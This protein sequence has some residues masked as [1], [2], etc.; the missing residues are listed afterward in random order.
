MCIFLQPHLHFFYVNC[1]DDNGFVRWQRSHKTTTILNRSENNFMIG[2]PSTSGAVFAINKNRSFQ[3]A[4][5]AMLSQCMLYTENTQT[6]R[7]T[8]TFLNTTTISRMIR[9]IQWHETHQFHARSSRT[10][11]ADQAIKCICCRWC[12]LFVG[13]DGGF[14]TQQSLMHIKRFILTKML[15]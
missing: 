6:C 11:L 15:S 8:T 13:D 12:C 4:T 9:T 1:S 2:N 14:G 10:S 3:D 5:L 7:V